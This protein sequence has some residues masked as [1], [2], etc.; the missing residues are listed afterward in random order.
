MNKYCEILC[1]LFTNELF[2][3]CYFITSGKTLREALLFMEGK[4]DTG[5]GVHTMLFGSGEEEN[6]CLP[7]VHSTC[8][9]FMAVF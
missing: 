3:E 9:K 4:E 1:R 8:W 7:D 5:F 2:V 6:Q